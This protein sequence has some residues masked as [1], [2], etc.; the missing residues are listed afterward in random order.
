[1]RG[2]QDTDQH[3][4]L[5]AYQL[6]LLLL[7]LGGSRQTPGTLQRVSSK[8]VQNCCTSAVKPSLPILKKLIAS[9]AIVGVH[10]KMGCDSTIFPT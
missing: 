8:L 6:Q 3:I 10:L 4:A 5:V 7:Q 1:M 9:D 2:A